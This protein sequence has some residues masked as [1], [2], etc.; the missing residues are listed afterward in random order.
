M[1][2]FDTAGRRLTQTMLQKIRLHRQGLAHMH[3]RLR[4]PSTSVQQQRQRV[5]ESARRLKA[6]LNLK[7]QQ[8]H[9]QLKTLNS[10]LLRCHP[11]ATVK[12]R[13]QE[14]NAH[15]TAL[16]QQISQKLAR[17]RQSIA[18]YERLLSSLGPTNTLSRGYAIVQ[19]QSG[20]VVR[21]TAQLTLSERLNVRIH[22]GA[23]GVRVEDIAPDA[24]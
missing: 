2:Q 23:I 11:I 12:Q 3:A 1:Q 20:E 14:L 16:S 4:N 24:E 21:D 15:R 6:A 17:H 5:D 7:L 9:Q 19:T 8:Q 22:Q 13:K 18:Q 10:R